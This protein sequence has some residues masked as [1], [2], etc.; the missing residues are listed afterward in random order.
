[1]NTMTLLFC[2]SGMSFPLHTN[3]AGWRTQ[4][5]GVNYLRL[6][7]QAQRVNLLVWCPIAN[8]C[9]G[10]MTKKSP[11][12]SQASIRPP[13]GHQGHSIGKAGMA[14]CRRSRGGAFVDITIARHHRSRNSPG[15]FDTSA[16]DA[17]RP[18]AAAAAVGVGTGLRRIWPSPTMFVAQRRKG[19]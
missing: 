15:P 12:K 3:A 7:T 19:G 13:L 5:A 14:D 10:E 16:V 6:T 4:P 11:E 1:M 2:S 8:G 17:L 18:P 9:Q